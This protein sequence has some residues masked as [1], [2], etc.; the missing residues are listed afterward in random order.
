MFAMAAVIYKHSGKLGTKEFIE[1]YGT[2]TDELNIHSLI[3][4]YWNIYICARWTTVS[5]IYVVMRDYPTFQIGLLYLLSIAT[6]CLLIRGRPLED[7]ICISLFNEI[8]VCAFLLNLI[9]L[10]D[11]NDGASDDQRAMVGDCLLG[12][13]L[14]CLGVNLL[15]VSY[16]SFR[17][18]KA[19]VKKKLREM[20]KKRVLKI[21][22]QGPA[23]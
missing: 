23:P 17:G 7:G 5:I 1:R 20:K 4:R 10:T 15:H 19:W 16:H 12:V 13:V 9:P 21:K 11:Y 3:G 6:Q 18:L 8:M 2:L 14:T 22:S